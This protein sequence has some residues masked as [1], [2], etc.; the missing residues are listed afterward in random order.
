MQPGPANRRT[1]GDPVRLVLTVISAA[2]LAW[3]IQKNLV[4]FDLSRPAELEYVVSVDGDE[5]RGGPP[6]QDET[7]VRLVAADGRLVR[8]KDID[9]TGTW[10]LDA[11]SLVHR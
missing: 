6:R 8:M 11:W 2:M 9:R 10:T 7:R 1:F 4:G 5:P 3:S